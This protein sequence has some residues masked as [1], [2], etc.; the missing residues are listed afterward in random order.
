MKKLKALLSRELD[1]PEDKK[2][3]LP[4]GYQQIGSI[5]IF[6]FHPQ[7][8]PYEKEIA[9]FILGNFPAFRTICKKTDIVRGE[10]RQPSV[11][12]IAGENNTIT[13]CNENGCI[14]RVDVSRVMFSQG[15][16]DERARIPKLVRKGETVI[17]MFAGIG[18]FTLPI[19]VLSEP[20]K[21]YSIEKNPDSVRLL[22][23]NVMLN[24][25]DSVV[26]VIH[27]DCRKSGLDVK[28]DR[29]IMGYLPNT[30]RFLGAAFDLLKPCGIIH[31]H[32]SLV[33]TELWK[34]PKETLERE[35]NKAG[36]RLK[37]I[38]REAVVKHYGPKLEHF[39]IDAVFERMD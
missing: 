21:V 23:K 29:I 7:I 12:V 22:E 39:V 1:I 37:R 34:R 14:Y 13:D 32:D 2:R 16:K 8:A 11:T 20:S 10:L 5:A 27:G 18:Y 4:R 24:K 3:F 38:Q 36:F 15:N 30:W 19:A 6:S 35:A 9:E 28:A 17:D 31:Y 25:V 26:E 33:Q